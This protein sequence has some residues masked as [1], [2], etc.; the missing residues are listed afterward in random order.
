MALMTVLHLTFENK[1]TGGTSTIRIPD[2]R[3][4][5]TAEEVQ[6]AMQKVVDIG[7]FGNR[8]TGLKGAKIVDTDT[9]DLDIM[10]V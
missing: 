8:M 4:D 7:L 9:Q 6:E 1:A 10:I 2:P 3:E 5:I